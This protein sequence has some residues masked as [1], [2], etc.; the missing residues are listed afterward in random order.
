MYLVVTLTRDINY[1]TTKNSIM[2]TFKPFFLITVLFVISFWQIEAQEN[3][4]KNGIYSI[5]EEMPEYP[6]GEEALKNE[7]AEKIKYP[8]EARKNGIQGKVFVTFVVDEQGAVSN[9]KIARGAEPSLDKEA[10]RVINTLK[11]WKPGKEKGKAVK[12]A[13][14]VPINFALG[15]NSKNESGKNN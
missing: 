1:L 4:D 11:T 12:V 6:G 2:K 3:P 5:V 8:E 13:F 10:L 15:D 9:V 14:T 7:I